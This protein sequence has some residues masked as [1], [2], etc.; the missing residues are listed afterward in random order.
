MI[1][2]FKSYKGIFFASIAFLVVVVFALLSLSSDSKPYSV[3]DAYGERSIYYASTLAYVNKCG[4]IY[5][6]KNVEKMAFNIP[7]GYAGDIPS[8]PSVVPMYG[9][10]S[11]ETIPLEQI[12]F[13]SYETVNK[14]WSES[15]ILATMFKTGVPVLWYDHKKVNEEEKKA[16]EYIGNQLKNQILILPWLSYEHE[17]LPKGRKFAYA[18]SGASQSCDVFDLENF[19]EFLKFINDSEFDRTP[20]GMKDA[21]LEDGVLPK[22][23]EDSDS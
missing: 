14:S 17:E 4:H 6:Y 10:L 23:S 19:V 1:K 15:Y 13:Y 22:F 16:L 7:E 21:V 2:K 8:A 11:K 9:Y 5:A 20:T 12:D 3:R 18:T